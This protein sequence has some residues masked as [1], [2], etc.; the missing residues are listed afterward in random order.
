[1]YLICNVTILHNDIRAVSV[2]CSNTLANTITL[3][4]RSFQIYVFLVHYLIQKC[5][6]SGNKNEIYSSSL[7]G[8]RF[9]HSIRRYYM[10]Y[11]NESSLLAP[12]A[13][14]RFSIILIVMLLI[15]LIHTDVTNGISQGQYLIQ[16]LENHLNENHVFIF[17]L[18]YVPIA[19]LYKVWA[20]PVM[21]TYISVLLDDS[22]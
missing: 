16:E 11:I 21:I 14:L 4:Y 15:S 1:M 22:I 17:A 5:C 7:L 2:D 8:K 19:L 13:L 6:R 3:D 18:I 12:N 10:T 20:Y 9:G